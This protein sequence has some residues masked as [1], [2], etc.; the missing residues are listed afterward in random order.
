MSHLLHKVKEAM[1]GEKNTPE[2]IAAN[3]GK[4]EYGAGTDGTGMTGEYPASENLSQGGTGH[5]T[6]NESTPS[7]LK[8]RLDSRDDSSY[9]RTAEPTG[10]LAGTTGGLSGSTGRDYDNT[11]SGLTG[12]SGRDTYDNSS[13][14]L[15]GST[16]RDTY[17]NTSSGLTGSSRQD[18]YDSTTGSSGAMGAMSGR[19]NYDSTTGTSGGMGGLSG[20]SGRDNYDSTTSGTTGGLTGGSGHHHKHEDIVHGG[21]HHSE[22]ANRLDPHVKT[23]EDGFGGSTGGVKEVLGSTGGSTMGS[24]LS[25]RDNYDSTGTSGGMG[26][27]LSGRDNYNSTTGTSGGMG[28]GLSGRDNYDSTTGTS[29][30]SGRDNYDSTTGTSGLSGRDNYDST[31]G[32]SGLS[33]RDNYDSTTG[34][35]GL[36]GRNNYGSNTDRTLVLAEDGRPLSAGT[37]APSEFIAVMGSP[38]ILH[39]RPPADFKRRHGGNSREYSKY[40]N[41]IE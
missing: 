25:G 26:S 12:T 5:Y 16:G 8:S 19:D 17:D 39:N 23:T 1:S 21:K 13:S 18:P 3:R 15:T 10:G 34:S 35:S 4:N 40:G 36:S 28:S 20:T 30:L 14:G 27:G 37:H 2:S 9:G 38:E 29:G 33:G 31:T 22:T 24:G 6:G 41:G 11:S 32:T 7:N